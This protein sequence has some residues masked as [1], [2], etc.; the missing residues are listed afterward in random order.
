[1]FPA[2]RSIGFYLLLCI[3]VVIPV[4]YVSVEIA[5]EPVFINFIIAGAQSVL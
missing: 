5:V 4:S 2:Y 3:R 1:M